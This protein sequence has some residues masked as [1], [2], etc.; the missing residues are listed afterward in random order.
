VCQS[1]RFD[2]GVQA[3]FGPEMLEVVVMVLTGVG[4]DDGWVVMILVDSVDEDMVLVGATELEVGPARNMSFCA[5]ALY[6]TTALYPGEAPL[7]TTMLS[8]P[9]CSVN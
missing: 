2:L 7:G 5:P 9:V 8:T 3:A 4:V 1:V 6:P